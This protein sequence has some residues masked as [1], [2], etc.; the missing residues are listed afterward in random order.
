MARASAPGPTPG[1]RARVLFARIDTN[2]SGR[3]NTDEMRKALQSDAAIRQELGWPGTGEELVALLARD[4]RGSFAEQAL[5]HYCEVRHLFNLI[6][7]NRSGRISA[8]ELETSLRRSSVV[9]EKLGVP[10]EL[11]NSL[12]EQIDTNGSGAI[13]LVEFYRYYTAAPLSRPYKQLGDHNAICERLFNRID[14]DGSGGISKGEFIDALRQDPEVQLELGQPARQAEQL[15]GFLDANQDGEISAGEFRLFCRAQWIFNGIDIN[16]SGYIDAFELGAALEDPTLQKELHRSVSQAQELFREIDTRRKGMLRF[17]DFY[18]W[19]EKQ[20]DR[21]A[22]VA[23]APAPAAPQPPRQH[24]RRA[25]ESKGKDAYCEQTLLAEG[26]FGKVYKCRRKSD[27]LVL[28]LKEPKP[29]AGATKEEV[30]AEADML[31]RLKHQCIVRFVD[32]YVDHDKLYIVTEFCAGGD[33]RKYQAGKPMKVE[34]AHRI[35][36]ETL[37]GMRYLHDRGILHRDLKPD[38]ILLTDTKAAKISDFGLAKQATGP[39]A[40]TAVAM[41]YCGTPFYMAPELQAG[42]AYGKPNDV[43]ALGCILYEMATGKLA[44][45]N[46]ADI[47]K[48]KVPADSPKWCEALVRQSLQGEETRRPT[49]KAMLQEMQRQG[50]ARGGYGSPP[51]GHV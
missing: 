15:F 16:R 9:R 12:F 43:W 30:A 34:E 47:V 45:T 50:P 28:I 24:H 4:G 42:Q 6:D 38:N 33:L 41:T 11:S 13:S 51:R 25:P 23:G 35:F 8:W 2:R 10:P 37:E 39:G 31:K 14:K 21:H 5:A 49:V 32:S 20:P 1:E 29:E 46:V 18:R 3:V 17:S 26:A 22:A 48:V 36:A 27:K 40:Q 7:T 44:F 19:L